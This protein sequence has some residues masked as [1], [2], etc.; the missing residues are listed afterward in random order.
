GAPGPPAGP[1]D[2]TPSGTGASDS[3]DPGGPA[4]RAIMMGTSG[5]QTF[6]MRSVLPPGLLGQF[7]RAMEIVGALDRQ[8][9]EGFRGEADNYEE[10]AEAPAD[11]AG[12]AEPN[13]AGPGPLSTGWGVE[14]ACAAMR[15]LGP[16]RAPAALTRA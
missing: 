11:D 6:D 12:A 7:D 13:D 16:K 15:L 4:R 1:T 5:G 2:A 10:R 3:A 14:D 8:R 9:H